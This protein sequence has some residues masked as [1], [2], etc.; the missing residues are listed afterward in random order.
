M[1]PIY[2]TLHAVQEARRQ[3]E[4]SF[5]ALAEGYLERIEARRSLNAYLDVYADEL[6]AQARA[7]D[8]RWTRGEAGPLAGMFLGIKDVIC[9]ARHP[10]RASSKILGNFRSLFT[11][12]ALERLL[13][14]DA[15]VIGSLNC[16]E[17]AMGSSN[18]NSAFGPVR[19]PLDEERVPGGS[20]GG[21]AAAVAAGLCLA[22]L[23]S[24][25]GGSVRQP[26]ALCGLVGFKPTYGRVSRY[27]LIAYASSFDQIGPLT[28]TVD[29]AARLFLAMGGADERDNTSATCPLESWADYEQPLTEPLHVGILR[30]AVETE[31]LDPEIRQA[32]L[33]TAARLESQGHRIEWLEFP[34]LEYLIPAYYV[35]TTAEASS[36]LARYDGVRYGYRADGVQNLE[37]LYTR[38]R[39]EGFGPEVKRRIALGT[40]VLSA[41]YKDAYYR[42]AQQVRRIIYDATR[43]LLKRCDVLLTP[44]TPTTAFRLGEKIDDPIAMY[45][46]DVYTVHANL[47]GMPAVS[48]PVGRHSNGLPYGLHL[49]AD[50]FADVRLLRISRDIFGL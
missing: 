36:N 42:K 24:D 29:D 47:V 6:L 1:K 7:L 39:S 33:D 35:L 14:Q 19:N 25:T 10:L 16:D 5:A 49:L 22:A 13:A 3:D 40:F 17:F 46:S 44:T 43:Q 4:I 45:L 26:A 31:G 18:E 23:G 34:Y 8:D 48:L 12:T 37:D 27:G 41:G 2:R 32:V 9:Y 50:S 20:S 15:L 21:S 30:E 28:H 11:A 38:T